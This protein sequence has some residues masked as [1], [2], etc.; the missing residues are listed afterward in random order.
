MKA[1]GTMGY[2][3]AE[4]ALLTRHGKA[5]VIAPAPEGPLGCRVRLDDGYDTD[6]LGTFS[7]EVP[8]RGSQLE[9][10]RTKA[11]IGME[12]TG[13]PLG[14]ASE[15]AFGPDPCAGL[16]SWNV[17]YSLAVSLELARNWSAASQR[18]SSSCLSS[19]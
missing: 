7:R 5:G 15:R 9:V 8:R 6:R 1:A 4:V 10:A 14:L 3:G 17:E 2:A 12:R 11:R 13:L 19:W 16:F 18:S